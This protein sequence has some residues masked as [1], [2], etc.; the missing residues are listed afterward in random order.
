M[1]VRNNDSPKT[2][3]RGLFSGITSVCPRES[4]RSW[5][6]AL[7]KLNQE[8]QQKN[9]RQPSK[10]NIERALTQTQKLLKIVRE[11][12]LWVKQIFRKKGVST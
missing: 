10:N 2:G 8:F 3:K 6:H 1:L 4:G 7:Q 12:P 9:L 5:L 11:I